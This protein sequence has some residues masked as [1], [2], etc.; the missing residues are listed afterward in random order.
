MKINWKIVVAIVVIVG[1]AVWG[2]SS[3]L[4]HSYSGANLTFDLQSGPVTVNNLSDTSVPV[5]LIG[6]GTRSFSVAGNI[7]GI[8]GTS[9]RVGSGSS[10]TQV[11]EYALPSG[12]SEFTVTRGS[13][14]SFVS[15]TDTR[16]EATV[17]PLSE[18]DGRTTLIV[19]AVVVLGALFYISRSTGHR[20]INSLR[21]K[22]VPVPSVVAPVVPVTADDPNRGHDGRMYSNY[23]SKD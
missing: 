10:S 17:Q 23:G 20:W 5:Q 12:V 3:V 13:D 8:G 2:V 4:P 9:T 16:L 15:N 14:V 19:A 7:E 18:T 22:Q 21:G 1:V 6:T 11:F